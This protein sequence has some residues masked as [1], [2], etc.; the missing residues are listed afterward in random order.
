MAPAGP[1]DA[2][3]GDAALPP[4]LMAAV[5]ASG[6]PA[7]GFGF[8]AQP[9]DGAD[10]PV[11]ASWNAEQ[12]F[13]MASTAKIV[14][15]LAA[16]DLLGSGP[17]LA[18]ARLRHHR[19]ERRTPGRRPGDRRRGGGGPHAGRI[20]PL[21][22]QMHADGLTA[23][24][25]RIVLEQFALLHAHE[26]SQAP[27]TASEAAPGGPP[28]PRTFTRGALVV[29]VGPGGGAKAAVAVRPHPPGVVVVNDVAMGGGCSAYARWDAVA[30]PATRRRC[31]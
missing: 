30:A 21:V 22:R 5:R 29:S 8:H 25:G 17:S 27:T 3:V 20:T 2:A 4:E 28:D 26:P 31:A 14:T 15:S 12:P 16:L 9:V 11:L 6:L 13:L 19:P 18:H 23:I 1:P 10:A 24:R 7:G